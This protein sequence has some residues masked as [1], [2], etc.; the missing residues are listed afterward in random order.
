MNSARQPPGFFRFAFSHPAR[1][2]DPAVSCAAHHLP[3]NTKGV[4]VGHGLLSGG[5]AA[6]PVLPCVRRAV[7]P[8]LALR[9]MRISQMVRALVCIGGVIGFALFGG[10]GWLIALSMFCGVLTS[11]GFV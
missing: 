5:A 8:D 6:V 4:L 3:D 1:G 9:L 10:I 2:S 11:E 7:R